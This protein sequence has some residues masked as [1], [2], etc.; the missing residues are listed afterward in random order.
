MNLN[1]RHPARRLRPTLLVNSALA[2]TLLAFA[3]VGDAPQMTADGEPGEP[4][5]DQVQAGPPAGDGLGD[6]TSDLSPPSRTSPNLLIPDRAANAALAHAMAPL[7]S[8]PGARLSVSVAALDSGTTATFGS[9]RFDTASIVKVNVLAAL[10]LEAQDEDREL[11]ELERERAEVMIRQSDNAATDA[12]W[13]QIGGAAGLTEA[14]ER[15]GLTAT[16]PGAGGHWGL[17]QTTSADQIALL[18][19]I[20]APDSALD[21]E[22]QRYLREL[23]ASVVDGQRWGISAAADGGETNLDGFELKNGWLPRSETGLWDVNS[24]GW[25]TARGRDYLVAVVSDGHSSQEAGIAAVEWAAE[26]AIHTLAA[27]A[28]PRVT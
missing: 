28:A 9:Q 12:L 13:W 4:A 14:N 24:I 18:R 5:S 11:T 27:G 15:L 10:L 26:A 1:D 17:T 6:I 16:T 21:A 20:Y 2:G 22:S 23:M 3:A 7:P 19:A 8:E 25:V